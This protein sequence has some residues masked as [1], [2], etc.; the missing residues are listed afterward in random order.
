MTTCFR[1]TPTPVFVFLLMEIFLCFCLISFN[2]NFLWAYCGSKMFTDISNFVVNSWPQMRFDNMSL[3]FHKFVFAL[4]DFY[5]PY[6]LCHMFGLCVLRFL[7]ADKGPVNVFTSGSLMLDCLV[8]FEALR[9]CSFI[10]STGS[11][12]SEKKKL[13]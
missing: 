1:G 4:Q 10:T 11:V 13:I 8:A 12:L 3:D 9:S 7:C 2:D 6:Y 5:T